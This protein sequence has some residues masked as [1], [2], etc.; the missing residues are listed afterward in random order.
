MKG[1]WL[2]AAALGTVMAAPGTA[3]TPR[4][5]RGTAAVPVGR[6]PAAARP[7]AY[8]LELTVLPASQGFS[9][10]SEIDVDVAKP[11]RFLYLH[12]LG[13]SVQKATATV[14][15]APVTAR[16]T[17]VD[18]S[19][20]VRLDF[21]APLPAGRTT[22]A[23]DYTAPFMTGSEGLYHAKVGDDWYAWT[24][25]EP[26]DARRMF[27]GFDEP[28]FKT[29][30]RIGITT[31]RELKAFANTP[32][33]RTT[34][35]G[36]GLVRHEFAASR[37]LPTYL[38][39]IA[40]GDFDVVEGPA[41]A[42]AVRPAALPYRVIATKGQK[43]R[44]ATAAAEGGRI[45]ALHEDYFGIPYP[46]EKLDQIASPVMQGAMEN[47]G[48]V[49]YND[50]LL[51][52]SPDAP[53]SQRRNFGTVVAHELAHQWFG[54][55]VTPVW[56][57]DIWLNESFAEWAGN[58][59]GEI[60]DPTLGTGV[61]Q[62]SEAL[63]AMDVDSRAA[64]RPIRQPIANNGEIASAFD[65]ITYQKGGQV[66]TMVER[67]LGP[68]K[69]RAGVRTHLDRFRYGSATAEDFFA[70]MAKGSGDPGIVPVFQS[71]VGQTGVPVVTIRPQGNVWR[72]TQA[73]YRPIGVAPGKPQTWALPFCVSE[74]SGAPTCTLMRGASA[75]LRLA[76]TGLAVPNAGG[77]GYYR[78]SLPD[79]GWQPLIA[80]AA[81]LPDRE[82]IALADS[83]WADFTAGNVTF[84]RVLD[85]TR[86]LAGHPNRIATA[87]LPDRLDA[88]S[89]STLSPAATAGYRRLMGSLYTPR[90]RA[91][92]LDVAAGAYAREDGER[93][94]TR[95]MVARIVAL[96]ARKADV[97]R[98]LA[99]AAERAVGGDARA[100]DPAYRDI[101]LRVAVQ[102]RGVAFMDR[103]LDAT[104]KSEDPLFRAN[105]VNALAGAETPDAVDRALAMTRDDRLQ[106]TERLRLLLTL[107]G[108]P[109]GR[110]ALFARLSRDW[111]AT[112]A[113][114]PAFVRPRL[115]TAFSSYCEPAKADAVEALFRPRMAS[116]GGGDL[117]LRQA[118]ESIRL[119]AA[120][121]AAKGAEMEA[122]LAR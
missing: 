69:F 6:L 68:D 80:R 12:G 97:R 107:S 105:A 25:M 84:A 8:R 108:Q 28:G 115:A 96:N 109:A 99:D 87:Q 65:S 91:L 74:G 41:P 50:A 112:T 120:L 34:P 30:F 66:L 100:L 18:P 95:R 94:Q 85:G 90:L 38:V 59:V 86:T 106:S 24:Q 101:A 45:L 121:K 78:Y 19:G 72:L 47:A 49:T 122:A 60:W 1:L 61:S 4:Q 16:W 119:C 104:A 31:H 76:G 36:D 64:G 102:D 22:L 48:L 114:I 110:D 26:I 63:E 113:D 33:V 67:Y 46:Y 62:L 42:N 43:A 13:L 27:P 2:A 88:V 73:R 14:R 35:A 58:R 89:A 20:V 79:A 54:D 83:L 111:D 103:L 82:A 15:G 17:E 29:P 56:W 117:E 40:V 71:F 116:L 57:N 39:A 51:L 98:Q 7:V 5:A 9:G 93:A 3:Q 10:H 53:P 44:L 81:G 55:L 32:E 11:T 118:T 37:P 70:S 77:A 21:D 75:T 23:F 92:G 52:L